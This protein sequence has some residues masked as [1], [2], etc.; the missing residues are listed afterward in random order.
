MLQLKGLSVKGLFVKGLF[1]MM[2]E[3]LVRANEF[4]AYE[5]FKKQ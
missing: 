5:E 3:C 4:S 2:N 1:V